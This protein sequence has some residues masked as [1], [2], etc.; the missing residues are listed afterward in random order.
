MRSATVSC[1]GNSSV[2]PNQF[3]IVASYTALVSNASRASRRRVSSVVS[4]CSRSSAS[5]SSY[6]SGLDTTVTCAKFLAAARS[7]DGPP[8]SIISTTSASVLPRSA[9]TVANG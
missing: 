6:C 7:I 3:A 4:P 9:A 2:S 5:T 1:S 8:T